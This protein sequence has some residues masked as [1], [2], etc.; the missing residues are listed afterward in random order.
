MADE[1]QCR[2]PVRL[3]VSQA[4]KAVGRARSTL[5]RDIA[6]G[7]VSVTR[8][9]TGQP[10]IEVAELERAYGKVDIRT[11]ETLAESVPNGQSETAPS[12]TDSL[13]LRREIE[14][15]RER[16][17]DK[18]AVI[19]DLRQQR[20]REA[21]ERRQAQAQLTA[22]LADRRSAPPASPAPIPSR[23]WRFWRRSTT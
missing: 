14:L 8:T 5:N 3:K 23:R 11:V 22:L 10:Y 4:A 7:K 19:D 12:D 6:N 20:D 2:S 16:L 17:V 18:D 15:L 21:G 13:L 9:G 1:G